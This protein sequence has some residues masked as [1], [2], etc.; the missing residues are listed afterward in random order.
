MSAQGIDPDEITNVSLVFQAAGRSYAM[1]LRGVHVGMLFGVIPIATNRPLK[2]FP[3]SS[4]FSW[5]SIGP[6]V[7]R[8][9]ATE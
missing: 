9:E 4:E 8:A 7:K 6:H 5:E 3:L 1:D 2:A